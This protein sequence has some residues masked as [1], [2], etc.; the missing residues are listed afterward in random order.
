MITTSDKPMTEQEIVDFINNTNK[1][2]FFVLV[3]RKLTNSEFGRIAQR[4]KYKTITESMKH[5]LD[6]VK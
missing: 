3:G 6:V 5:T 2:R 1:K 4:C